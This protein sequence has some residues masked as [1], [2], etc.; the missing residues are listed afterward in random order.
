MTYK[1]T[2]KLGRRIA[3]LR[4]GGMSFQSIADLLNTEGILTIKSNKWDEHKCRTHAWK[5]GS[6]VTT[7]QVEPKVKV[8]KKSSDAD[9]AVALIMGAN[10]S[11]KAKLQAIK[12]IYSN[13]R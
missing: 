5:W 7:P 12:A 10:L 3:R 11:E 2:K 1:Q 4:K 13:D 6:G 9:A 8:V